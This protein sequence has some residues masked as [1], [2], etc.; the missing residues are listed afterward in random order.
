MSSEEIADVFPDGWVGSTAGGTAPECTGE[1]PRF[2][3]GAVSKRLTLKKFG[4]SCN[5]RYLNAYS[6]REKSG[7]CHRTLQLRRV[8]FPPKDRRLAFP[9]F[10]LP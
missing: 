10:V 8:L 6:L 1:T 4:G 3:S 5:I 2:S 9:P 7:D